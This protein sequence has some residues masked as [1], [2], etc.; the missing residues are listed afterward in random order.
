M[1][2]DLQHLGLKDR[3]RVT[4]TKGVPPKK[5]SIT[6][7]IPILTKPSKAVLAQLLG[8]KVS[9]IGSRVTSTEMAVSSDVLA[10]KKTVQA[11]CPPSSTSATAAASPDSH[12][13]AAVFEKVGPEE[14]AHASPKDGAQATNHSSL[15]QSGSHQP[16]SDLVDG[17]GDTK[18]SPM[19]QINQGEL[20]DSSGEN[21]AL[22][23]SNAAREAS[24][25]EY[26]DSKYMFKEYNLRRAKRSATQPAVSEERPAKKLRLAVNEKG[27]ELQSSIKRERFPEKE[28]ESE[29]VPADKRQRLSPEAEERTE[30]KHGVTSLLSPTR[31]FPQKS[32]ESIVTVLK[33]QA[34]SKALTSKVAVS[35]VQLQSPISITEPLSQHMQ[36]SVNVTERDTREGVGQSQE[37][38][39]AKPKSSMKRKS[40]PVKRCQKGTDISHQKGGTLAAR[41]TKCSLCSLGANISSL[42]FL[43]GPYK[44]KQEP[45]PHSEERSDATALREAGTLLAL[46]GI[47]VHEDCT[48]WAPGVCLVGNKLIGLE[49]A[50]NDARDMVR[51]FIN[52]YKCVCTV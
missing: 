34:G 1:K 35:G 21:K 7:S 39:R 38:S 46:S 19:S 29:T 13:S 43:F 45:L 51:K 23:S 36:P 22:P 41:T 52:L 28:Q 44:V 24:S 31:K 32:L 10:V 40:S 17:C 6:S 49:E 50:I 18:T 37:E 27:L 25:F 16:S 5:P 30:V 9:V 3:E 42:G 48:V 8:E 33:V 11:S 20:L 2:D 15:D 14:R 26:F 4:S 12:S 47:W